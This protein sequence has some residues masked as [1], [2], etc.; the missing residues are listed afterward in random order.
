MELA[1]RS[2][3]RPAI[4]VTCLLAQVD[5]AL[6]DARAE[7]TSSVAGVGYSDTKLTV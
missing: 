5:P 3:Q 7:A 1:G 2:V 6:P 4:L